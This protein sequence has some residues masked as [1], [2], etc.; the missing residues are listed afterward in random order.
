MPEHALA[1]HRGIAP[2][3]RLYYRLQEKIK[4]LD[5]SEGFRIII[6][7]LWAVGS[8]SQAIRETKR[9][10][11]NAKNQVLAHATA[12]SGF[13]ASLAGLLLGLL[14]LIGLPG[15]RGLVC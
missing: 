9:M 4:I 3:S 1:C 7:Q 2:G 10:F 15:A 13:A 11:S 14:L 5:F 6:T 12:T 8:A